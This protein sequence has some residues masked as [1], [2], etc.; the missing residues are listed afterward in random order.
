MSDPKGFVRF[1]LRVIVLHVAT[2]F[3]FGF[4]FSRVFRYDELFQMDIIRDFM[5]PYESALTSAIGPFLFQPVRGLLFAI[6]IWP[7][8]G[9]LLE[10]RRG[11]LI[12]WMLFLVF[13]IFS[14]PAAAPGSI[15]GALYSR[16]PLWYHLIGL[17]EIMLQTLAFSATLIWWEKQSLRPAGSLQAEHPTLTELVKAVM[18][19]SFAWIGYAIGGLLSVVLVQATTGT[20]VDTQAAASNLT[21]QFMFVVA[22]VVNIGCAFILSRWWGAGRIS[23]WLMFGALWVI[24]ALVPLVYQ[25]IVLSAPSSLPIAALL[26][27]F[28]ALIITA[29]IYFG[30]P[31]PARAGNSGLHSY[32]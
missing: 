9:F 2:Y 25:A 6:A 7:L 11:W 12:L 16:L 4:V 28:P 21:L 27:F 29:T 8:R 17:P 31:R 18:A 24:D 26:G 30:H 5:R 22:F 20:V 14:P 10:Q 15:E 13:G 3:L 32:H 1:A 19:S 23:L